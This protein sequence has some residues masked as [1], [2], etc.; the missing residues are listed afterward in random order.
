MACFHG[1]D[2]HWYRKVHISTEKMYI[3]AFI[4]CAGIFL[5]HNLVHLNVLN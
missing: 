5:W 1:E 2:V 4:D 3:Q